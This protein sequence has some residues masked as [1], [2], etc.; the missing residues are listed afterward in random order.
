M[1]YRITRYYW[2]QGEDYIFWHSF[3]TKQKAIDDFYKGRDFDDE[4]P[5]HSRLLK[6]I[7]APERPID[8]VDEFFTNLFPETRHRNAGD[9]EYV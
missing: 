8:N 9:I 4:N 7:E 1:F 6:V 3:D 2:R 5:V